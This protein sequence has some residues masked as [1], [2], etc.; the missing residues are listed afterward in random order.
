M[1]TW[2]KSS[3]SANSGQE[4]CVELARL[5]DLVGVRDSKAP[6]AGHLSLS[7]ESFA[8]LVARVKRD[9]QIA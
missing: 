7:A 5:S 9:E 1:T 6:E 2:R 4:N 3:R 8:E